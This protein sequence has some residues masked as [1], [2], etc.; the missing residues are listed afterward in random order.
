MIASLLSSV[1]EV[2]SL[3]LQALLALLL[4]C[5]LALL[6][7]ASVRSRKAL[8]FEPFT[9]FS[10]PDSADTPLEGH[11]VAD[12]L[13]TEVRE[14]QSVHRQSKRGLD[15]DNPYYDIPAFQQDLDDDLKLLAS[16][17]PEGQ[18]ALVSQ[19][20]SVMLALM[21]IRP[22]R[23]T[24]SIHRVDGT[25]TLVANIEIPG[26]HASQWRVGGVA[27]PGDELAPL[28]S[29]LAYKVYLELATTSAFRSSDAFR[30]YTEAVRKH[31]AYGDNERDATVHVE[32]ERC[33]E[34]ARELEPTNPAVLY[35][36][37][38]L[39]YYRYEARPN[40]EAIEHF[41]SALRFADG[42]LK[43]QVH[44]GLANALIQSHHRF[45]GSDTL[46]AEARDHARRALKIGGRLDVALKA[47]AFAHHQTSEALL[48]AAPGA[49]ERGRRREVR[50]HRSKAIHLYGRT[51]RVNPRYYVAFNNLANLYLNWAEYC[52]PRRT[53]HLLRLAERLSLQSIEIKPSYWHAYD[54][55]GN[56]YR[57]LGQLGEVERFDEALR[58][59]EEARALRPDYLPARHDLALLHLCP[60]WP[61]RDH[62]QAV[63]LLEQTVADASPAGAARY[64]ATFLAAARAADLDEADA[65]GVTLRS[66]LT[67]GLLAR[68]GETAAEP[69]PVA[70]AR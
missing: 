17:S 16:A 37:G 9:E 51:T 21:P 2:I 48:A 18:G 53:K 39:K 10:R 67:P 60:R 46:L 24:G 57:G 43:A 15:L 58:Y 25:V 52:H 40:A 28:V 11:R 59:Y 20:V 42:R 64:E 63:A 61:A 41:R 12:L 34:Q 3:V 68:V 5:L 29:D 7:S 69:A 50:R 6:A 33:Y 54:N 14:I 13:L 56:A 49:D 70:G 62:R 30:C 4:M 27:G 65:H 35:N 26:S 55:A 66:A 32:A 31:L 8:Q 22:G 1:G 19:L 23:L 36:L 38:V 47:L 44:S 45:G